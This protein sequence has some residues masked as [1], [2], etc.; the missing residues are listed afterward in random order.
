[1]PTY[2]SNLNDPSTT[3]NNLTD[4]RVLTNRLSTNGDPD[5]SD[6]TSTY[7]DLA[8]AFNLLLMELYQIKSQVIGVYD[9]SDPSGSS[10]TTN[11]N[12]TA[13]EQAYISAHFGFKIYYLTSRALSMARA[14]QD[15]QADISNAV[16]AGGA[17]TPVDATATLPSDYN[18]GW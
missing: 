13:H 16:G 14:I 9:I 7:A 15:L 10:A 8:T 6:P 18:R 17:Q 4:L 3:V 12:I 11:S 2:P 1:M 5:L